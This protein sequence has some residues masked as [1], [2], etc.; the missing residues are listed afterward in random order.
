MTDMN[1]E[2]H[3]DG[4]G[5]NQLLSCNVMFAYMVCAANFCQ[6]EWL[7]PTYTHLHPCEDWMDAGMPLGA[8]ESHMVQDVNAEG[9]NNISD[10]QIVTNSQHCRFTPSLDMLLN[11]DEFCDKALKEMPMPAEGRWPAGMVTQS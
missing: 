2:L 7:T 9:H 5:T 1:A 6:H 11:I 8:A 3:T 4:Y 10:Q